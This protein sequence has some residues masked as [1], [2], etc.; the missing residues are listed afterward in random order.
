MKSPSPDKRM[1][2]PVYAAAVAS[3]LLFGGGYLIGRLSSPDS[4]VEHAKTNHSAHQFQTLQVQKTELPVADENIVAQLDSKVARE[5]TVKALRQP[6]RLK[7]LRDFTAILSGMDEKNAASID[8]GMNDV[9]GAGAKLNSQTGMVQ[10][11]FGQVLKSKSMAIIPSEPNGKLNYPPRQRM[12]GWA[13]VDPKGAKEWLDKLEPGS[14]KDGLQNEWLSGLSSA[15]AEVIQS[16]F[17]TL[18]PE[19]QRGVVDGLLNGLHNEGG[20]LALSGWFEAN[21][22]H[23]DPGVM[24]E[25]LKGIMW[26][27]GQSQKE[28]DASAEFVKRT[29]A[30]GLLNRSNFETL[31]RNIVVAISSTAPSLI[32]ASSTMASEAESIIGS[33]VSRSTASSIN[34]LGEWL[35]THKDHPLYDRTVQQFS[36]RM[37]ANDPEAA[38]QWAGTIKDESTRAQTLTALA[39][40]SGK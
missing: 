19:Q 16:I 37:N 18:P 11:R 40:S 23:A 27:M 21:S 33:I 35:N 34:T 2:I 38:L 32:A 15:N 28:W 17:P 22:A 3:A 30:S 8:A 12:N 31:T 9:Y 24:Q 5:R 29:A 39:K 14:V 6:D 7:R 4:L 20:L 25:A 1:K 36:V 13:S 26:R 10:T